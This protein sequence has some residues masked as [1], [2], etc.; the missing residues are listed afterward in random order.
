[1]RTTGLPTP[2]PPA[3]AQRRNEVHEKL[4]DF[5]KHKRDGVLNLVHARI[6]P[7][8]ACNVNVTV[9]TPYNGCNEQALF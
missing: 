3:H 1:M 9:L 6:P 4:Q 7:I 2:H 8:E 5:S